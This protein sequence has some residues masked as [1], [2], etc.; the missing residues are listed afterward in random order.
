MT[1]LY[2]SYD[3]RSWTTREADPEDPWDNGDDDGSYDVIGVHL[4]GGYRD[5]IDSHEDVAVG[6]TV[7]VVWV[8]YGSGSTFGTDGGYG[9]IVCATKNAE[10]AQAAAMWADGT[11]IG[12][13]GR[14]AAASPWPEALGDRQCTYEPWNGYFEWGQTVKIAPFVVQP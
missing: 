13:Y 11:I 4:T 9:S 2:C 7:W 3:Q 12:G 8:Q 14:K 6:D 5:A 10:L 1:Q